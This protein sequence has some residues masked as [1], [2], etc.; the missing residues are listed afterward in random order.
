MNDKERAELSLRVERA[1]TAVG[2]S[3]EAAAR[4]AGVTTTTWRRVESGLRV[5]DHKLQAILAAVGLDAATLADS[6]EIWP[7]EQWADAVFVMP[8]EIERGYTDTA[9]FAKAVQDH[10]PELGNRAMRLMLDA[11][12]LFAD[13]GNQLL[14]EGGDGDADS[15]EPGGPAPTSVRTPL[16]A[17]DDELAAAAKIGDVEEP[18]EFNT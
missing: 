3:K 16:S 2:L 18:G 11:A 1:R 13:A 12:Q 15:T 10:V 6:P 7:N 14:R 8:P 9:R 4:K 17:V 5:H